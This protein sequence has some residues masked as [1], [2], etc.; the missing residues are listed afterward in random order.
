MRFSQLRYF[1]AACRCGSLTK[2]AAEFQI[3]QPALSKAVK[4]LEEELEVELFRRVGKKL[5]LTEAGQAFWEKA[6]PLLTHADRIARNMQ[7]LGGKRNVVNIATMSPIGAYVVD[8]PV[9]EFR[10]ARPELKISVRETV[11][12]E[13]LEEI[14]KE[15][16][17][18]GILI[19][20]RISRE[21]FSVLPFARSRVVYCMRPKHPLAGRERLSF[22]ELA[23]YPMIL[24]QHDR[25]NM[26]AVEREMRRQGLSPRIILRTQQHNTAF[27][28]LDGDTGYFVMRELAGMQDGVCTA[29]LVESLADLE[30][31]LVWKKGKRLY[32]DTSQFVQF[33]EEEY[34]GKS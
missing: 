32:S 12:T 8:G 16:A 1:V 33:I 17:D 34:Q 31:G 29:E 2:A 19:V 7:N 11:K 13:V 9:R 23:P 25:K 3:S 27:Q 22:A 6:E 14:K 5:V 20:N 26:P 18:V 4:A 28:V 30:I 24:E 21:D 10:K 15:R